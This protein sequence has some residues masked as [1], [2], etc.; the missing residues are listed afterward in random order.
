MLALWSVALVLVVVGRLAL[1]PLRANHQA[2]AGCVVLGAASGKVH[3]GN[4]AI[5]GSQVPIAKRRGK[6]RKERKT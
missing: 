6:I 5:V 2:V 3:P 4:A 1:L